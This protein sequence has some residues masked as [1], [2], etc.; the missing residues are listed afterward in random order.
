MKSS[1][2]I[3]LVACMVLLSLTACELHIP[4]PNPPVDGDYIL[5]FWIEEARG[6]RVNARIEDGRVFVINGDE[7]LE[8]VE[9]VFEVRSLSFRMPAFNNRFELERSGKTFSGTWHNFAKGEDYTIPVSLKRGTVRYPEDAAGDVSGNWKVTFSAGTEDE[10]IAEG[11]FVQVGSRV[12]GT[13]RTTTGDYRHLQG[14][15][16]GHEL[17]LSCF[18]GAH[19]FLFNAL[20][21]PEALI[22]GTFYSG[23]HWQEPWSA[24]RVENYELPDP[25]TLTFVGAGKPTIVQITGTWCPN[26]M[27]ETVLLNELHQRYYG[28]GLEIVALAFEPASGFDEAAESIERFRQ[29][30][31]VRYPILYAGRADKAEAVK[32]L[33]MLNHIMSFPT[34]LFFD[35]Q[36]NLLKVHTGFNGPGTGDVYTSFVAEIT[37]LIENRML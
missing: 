6:I 23:K 26:C 31:M 8:A 24:V 33:P 3:T 37:E 30:M 21:D 34:T 20:V 27:D 9:V 12:T 7:V 5:S 13:F 19:L 11:V 17:R 16:A 18:D 15:V 29:D 25:D 10:H 32:A 36:G 1:M 28:Q 4:D 14:A 2:L 22:R 35:R